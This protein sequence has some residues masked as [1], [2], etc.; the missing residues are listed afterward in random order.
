MIFVFLPSTFFETVL[1]LAVILA[2]LTLAAL[3]KALY[4]A[5]FALGAAASFFLRAAT[6]FWALS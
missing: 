1:A 3:S 4:A 6:F 2:S 5:F